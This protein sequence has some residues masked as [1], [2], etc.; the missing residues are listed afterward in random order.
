MDNTIRRS[1]D[2]IDRFDAIISRLTDLNGR[3]YDTILRLNKK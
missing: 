2:L 1:H 3:Y